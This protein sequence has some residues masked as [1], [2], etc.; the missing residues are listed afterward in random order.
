M[1]H[2]VQS[3]VSRKKKEE[4]R[5]ALIAHKIRA[6]TFYKMLKETPQQS[7]TFCFDLQQVQPLPKL[8]ICEAFYARQISFYAFCITD[9][10]N[11][12]PNFYCWTE[13]QA[14]R[15]AQEV[16]SA[17]TN[18]LS[19]ENF[20]DAVT[21]IRLF[22][23]GCG[24]QNR[25]SIVVHAL[26]WWLLQKSP[27][28]VKEICMFFPVRGH[29]S[30]PADRMFGII[31]KELRR[32]SE[33]LKPEDYHNLYRNVGKVSVL[34]IDWK[35]QD[36]KAFTSKLHKL[37][38]ISAMKR[39]RLKKKIKASKTNVNVAMEVSYRLDD[40]SRGHW[41]S[42]LKR[43]SRVEDIIQPLNMPFCPGNV[44]TAKKTDVDRLLKQRFGDEW[45]NLSE[46]QFYENIIDYQGNDAQNEEETE[47]CDCL[48]E[49]EGFGMI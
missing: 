36:F 13:N 24:G 28:S 23:D 31:E 49:E 12:S 4:T 22:S 35:V 3:A 48:D 11:K 29:S 5:A 21:T 43:G 6:K 2:E 15:G 8:S 26:Y 25:N 17:L 10:E 42:L 27:Q 9:V 16:A 30:L 20:D 40:H 19:R 38:G 37:E 34:G 33:I 7:A 39:V 46:L 18:F 44:K 45:R 14:G 1:R 47:R 32:N 41:S